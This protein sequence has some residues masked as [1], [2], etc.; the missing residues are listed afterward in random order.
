MGEAFQEK[1]HTINVLPL[2]KAMPQDATTCDW[3]GI[4]SPCFSSQA[5]TPVKAFLRSLPSLERTR[6][7]V[8][9]TSSGAPGRVLYDLAHLLREKGADVVGGFLTRGECYH[10]A[11]ALRGR[12]PGR[13]HAK[14]LAEARRF[15][16]SVA[17][18]LAAG[19]PG[20]VAES[21]PDPF[22]PPWGFY[23]LV[24]LLSTDGFLR[25]VL[26]APKLDAARCIRC[27][28]CARECPVGN[29]TLQPDPVLG[30]HCI[31]CYRCV[32]GCPQQAFEVDWRWGNLAVLLFY[33]KAFER[34]F[35]DLKP[36]ERID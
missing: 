28:W 4:G 18:H 27:G 31:R 3:L 8:F 9:A 20:P 14:D 35:G 21:R 16:A 11:P 1:G 32:T 13:P 15:A 5:P 36:G 7:F 24:G 2:E 29:L 19:R 6:A 26:P 34:W 25:C 33:N 10:P 23:E 22:R 12:M 17:D 30:T